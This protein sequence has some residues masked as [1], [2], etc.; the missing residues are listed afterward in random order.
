MNNPVSQAIAVSGGVRHLAKAIGV[1]HPTII[2]WRD[3][4]RVPD[5]RNALKIQAATGLNAYRL[6]LGDE[7]DAYKEQLN[8]L[9]G[10]Y[11]VI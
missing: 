10:A 6:C 7:Y 9:N 3:N 4:G 8:A 1:P 5:L 11:K 2:N